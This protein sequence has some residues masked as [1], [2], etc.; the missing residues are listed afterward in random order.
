MTAHLPQNSWLSLFTQGRSE[1]QVCQLF[2]FHFQF[3]VQVC[4]PLIS[5]FPSFTFE[6]VVGPVL[7]IHPSPHNQQATLGI[8]PI[9]LGIQFIMRK[10]ADRGVVIDCASRNLLVGHFY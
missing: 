6:D 5:H 3:H 8:Y 1:I 4:Q 9:Q 2:I 10:D 7:Y